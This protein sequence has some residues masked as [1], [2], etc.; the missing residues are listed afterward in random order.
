MRRGGR[1]GQVVT[2]CSHHGKQGEGR[3]WHRQDTGPAHWAGQQTRSTKTRTRQQSSAPDKQ[4]RGRPTQG[5][6][7]RISGRREAHGAHRPTTWQ[8][9]RSLSQ[10]QVSEDAETWPRLTHKPARH[11]RVNQ[12]NGTH[13]SR[14]IR[15]SQK[16]FLIKAHSCLKKEI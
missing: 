15:F 3:L 9:P 10:G 1:K 7:N 11:G 16:Q 6:D 13:S 8:G 4:R 14:M 12:E 5:K 2:Q